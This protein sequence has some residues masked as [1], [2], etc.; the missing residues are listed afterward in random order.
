MPHQVESLFDG[1]VYS[2]EQPSQLGSP[3][4]ERH[5]AKHVRHVKRAARVGAFAAT[6]VIVAAGLTIVPPGDAAPAGASGP[7]KVYACY[8][9]TTGT[10]SYLNYPKV[11]T[12]ASGSTMISWNVRGPQGA[13][14]PQGPQGALGP[15]GPQGALGPQGPQGALGPQ[16][17]QG[18]RGAT[19]VA[20]PQGVS[21]PQGPQGATG[22]RGPSGAES[23]NIVSTTLSTPLNHS[24]TTVASFHPVLSRVGTASLSSFSSAHWAI[25]ATV[26]FDA[27][28]AAAAKCWLA[29][30]H[31]YFNMSGTAFTSYGGSG[32]PDWGNLTARR[33]HADTIAIT[34]GTTT[35]F[36]TDPTT[37]NSL[38]AALRCEAVSGSGL[39][40]INVTV[41]GIQT[42]GN[43]VGASTN[44]HP[45]N[46]FIQGR[47]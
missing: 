31:R 4:G 25:E 29:T 27:K 41:T 22:A 16:G 12:C 26:T 43:N 24:P 28:T 35:L 6:G 2:D 38:T 30:K 34:G 10:L 33:S 23:A 36:E 14:G 21:G 39:K 13:L 45:K 42:T 17:P 44:H 47:G 20:G 32:Q 3:K 5:M 8:S 11:T 40:A 7:A 15:Q 37:S 19:G 1:Q 46:R 9:D 18:K